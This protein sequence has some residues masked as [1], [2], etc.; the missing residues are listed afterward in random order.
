MVDAKVP[1]FSE[2]N[3]RGCLGSALLDPA[4]FSVLKNDFGLSP[5]AFYLPAH[6]M[7][8]EAMEELAAEGRPIDCVTVGDAMKRAGDLD[9]V[10]GPLFLDGLM[11][12]TPTAAHAEFYGEQVHGYW[13]RRRAIEAGM[14]VIQLAQ[15]PAAGDGKGAAAKGIE[16]LCEVLEEEKKTI[17]NRQYLDNT[18]EKWRK[19]AE[20]RKKGEVP[21]LMGLSTGLDRLDDLLNGMKKGLIVLAARQS[22]GKTALEGQ[23]ATTLCNAG[24]PVLRI[25]KD[26]DSQEL[27]DRDLCRKA[28]VSLAKMEKGYMFGEQEQQVTDGSQLMES[29]PM[30]C[31]DELWKI[32][33]VVA[34]IRADVAKRRKIGPDGKPEPYLFTIDYLQLLRTGIPGVDDN[35]NGRMDECTARIKRIATALGIP[36]LVLSQ[37][38]RDKDMLKGR[39]GVNWLDTRPIMEDIKDCG[40]IEQMA[41]VVI[42]M[43]K[44]ADIPDEF[45]NIGKVTIVAVDVAKNKNGATGPIFMRFDRPYFK[46]T[47]LTGQEQHAVM[48]FLHDERLTKGPMRMK[49][50][51]LQAPVF[52]SVADAIERASELPRKGH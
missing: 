24:I 50:E 29:W 16:V 30:L 40:S 35:A 31:E 8:W 9:K 10:G 12:N 5:G 38:A 4:A 49:P 41:H 36:A 23:I 47:E 22:T 25:T 2:E 52:E 37:V 51:K 39:G 6:R 13:S 45:G 26:S 14:R 17:T 3:E 34:K 28:G 11:E 19:Q 33:D 20:F 21:P 1:P 27:W 32:K 7:V 48:K 46:W 43:S 15:D 44:V 18:I 42:L